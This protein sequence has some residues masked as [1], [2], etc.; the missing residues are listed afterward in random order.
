MIH[1]LVEGMRYVR[2]S[3]PIMAVVM[4]VGLITLAAGIKQPLEPLFAL[5]ALDAGPSGYGLLG[6]VWGLG[7]IAITLFATRLDR[8]FGR[9]ALITWST[10][11]VGVAVLMAAGSPA[12][13]PVLL[14]WLIAGGANTIGTVAYETLIQEEAPD[15]VRGRVFAAVEA[16]I[17]AGFLGGVAIAALAEPVFGSHSSREGLAVSG[18]V[19]LAAGFVSWRMLGARP[20]RARLESGAHSPLRVRGLELVPAGGSLS[21]LRLAVDG[22]PVDRPVLLIDDGSRV[23]RVEPLPAGRGDGLA[24]GVPSALLGL[25]RTALALEVRGRGLVD[26]ALPG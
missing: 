10:L 17:H 24:Y 8:H 5:R 23:H 9:Q 13:A 21:L 6:G 22:A 2:R 19:F 25:R 4:I 11:L 12:L 16:S 3:R 26:I 18:A 15:R 7:M 1:E 20:A 14:L